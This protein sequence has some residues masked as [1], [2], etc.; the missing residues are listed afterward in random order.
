VHFPQIIA[1]NKKIDELIQVGLAKTTSVNQ[2][3]GVT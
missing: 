2:N 3:T 1:L